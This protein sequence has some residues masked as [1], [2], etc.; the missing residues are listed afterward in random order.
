[1]KKLESE[2]TRLLDAANI[3]DRDWVTQL[4]RIC[5]S[6]SLKGFNQKLL[7]KAAIEA[8]KYRL[9]VGEIAPETMVKS[10]LAI[11]RKIPLTLSDIP[12]DWDEQV[13]G[14]VAVNP[15][16]IETWYA[17][18]FMLEDRQRRRLL[19][20]I[21]SMIDEETLRIDQ[22][23]HYKLVFLPHTTL[24]TSHPGQKGAIDFYGTKMSL[25]EL[26]DHPANVYKLSFQTIGDRLKSGMK[27]LEALTSPRRR[28]VIR[29]K[30]DRLPKPQS[31]P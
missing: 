20:H 7:Y 24:T 8:I 28:T 1:M 29:G 18:K 25:R 17:D 15:G 12:E 16:K 9:M 21:K 22:R 4:R 19:A 10:Y 23:E 31:D 30:E 26:A 5:R 11:K 13:I 27:P 2:L 14:L 6:D 3:I